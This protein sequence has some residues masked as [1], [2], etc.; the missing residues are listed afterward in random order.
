MLERGGSMNTE[1]MALQIGPATPVV[2]GLNATLLAVTGANPRVMVIQSQ[3]E[4][5]PALPF[6]PL[7]ASQ[8]RTL[9]LALRRWVKTKTDLDLG[10][11]EQLY[12]FGDRNRDQG[13]HNADQ[14]VISIAYLALMQEE[15][16]QA[17]SL[18]VSWANVYDFLPW[19]DR[20]KGP[21]SGLESLILPRLQDWIHSVSDHEVALQRQLRA[22]TAFGATGFPWDAERV[23]ERCELLYEIGLLEE[24]PNC[25]VQGDAKF[26]GLGKAMA[27]DHRR[28]L[29]TALGRLRGKV[30]Y[31]PVVFEMLPEEFTLLQLQK[32]VEALSGFVLHKQNFRRLVEQN[33]LVEGT[34]KLS[35]SRG[36]P[37]ELFRFRR[38]VL[39]ER[40]APGLGLPKGL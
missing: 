36:R 30:R 16:L 38:E 1:A 27:Q 32:T 13:E 33:R 11:V 39:R 9:E 3:S 18:R 14:R 7:D 23:L 22:D 8:D 21:W 35:K 12:S 6:G 26:R 2:V 5:H 19:E 20:R 15:K 10:Y 25:A 17:S 28:I 40:P 29:A 31:R 24:S 37:A 4:E 34:D